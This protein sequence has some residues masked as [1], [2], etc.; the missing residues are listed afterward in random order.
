MFHFRKPFHGRKNLAK[1][2]YANRII[3]YFVT[4]FAAMATDVGRRK[5]RLSAFDSPS[6]KTL[7]NCQNLAKISYP[8]WVTAHFVSD[9]VAMVTEINRQKMRFAAF[10]GPS[11]KPPYER[12]NLAKIIYA[13]RVIAHYMPNFVAMA[14]RIGREKMWLAAFDGSFSKKFINEKISQKFLTQAALLRILSQ[15]SL[16]WQRVSMKIKCDWQHSMVHSWKPLYMR[17][18]LAKIFFTQVAL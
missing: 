13:S 9:F 12:K 10:D 14:T 5:M 11:P 6:P 7:Y 16:T 17:N 4:N 18:N 8:S 2:S 3:A 1:I 15:I